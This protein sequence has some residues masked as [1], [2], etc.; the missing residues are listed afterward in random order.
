MNQWTDTSRPVRDGEELDAATLETYLR[1]HIGEAG[2]A[3]DLEI[4]QFPGGFSNLTYL[5]RLGELELVLR[6]PPFGNRVKSA[7][8][9]GREFRVLDK[10][11][12]VYPPAPRPY[13]YCDDDEVIGAPFY[14]ME[15]RRGVILRRQLPAG[16]EISPEL[17]PRLSEAFIDNLAALHML[18]YEAAG[19]AGLGRPEGYVE[20]QVTGWVGRYQR[21][22]TDDWPELEGVGT[23]LAGNL[24]GEAAHTL[25]HNDYKYDNLILGAGD[26]TR[27]VAVLDWEMCTLGDPLMDL[28]STLAYWVEESDDPHWRAAAFG[29]TDVPGSWRRQ[30]LVERYAEVTGFDVGGMTFY[31]AFGLYK[32]AVIAQQIYYRFAKGH[33]QDRRFAGMNQ[34]VGL[35][36]RVGQAAIER[37]TF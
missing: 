35:L 13:L 8:D 16:L 27:I 24:P 34:M 21:A 3:A 4:E 18:D 20:R 23:W 29:P 32:L 9:M 5:L 10:L 14:V 37:G 12:P 28:G 22:R 19:L 25:I 33:T 11:H 2:A 17:A 6:R 15:R 1:R 36:G 26:L 30:Q 7:H 31:Y